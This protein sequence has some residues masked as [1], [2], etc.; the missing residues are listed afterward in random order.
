[1]WLVGY[2]NISPEMGSSLN[3]SP[4]TSQAVLE[5]DAA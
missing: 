3:T 1:M 4:K 2:V 5:C